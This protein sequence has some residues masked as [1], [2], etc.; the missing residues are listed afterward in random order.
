MCDIDFLFKEDLK[1]YVVPMI[2]QEKFDYILACW[3]MVFEPVR[4]YIYTGIQM[5]YELMTMIS[6]SDVVNQADLKEVVAFLSMNK[7]KYP[8]EELLFLILRAMVLTTW[9]LDIRLLTHLEQCALANFRWDQ[10]L[11]FLSKNDLEGKQLSLDGLPYWLR[12]TS[13]GYA[14]CLP[15]EFREQYIQMEIVMVKANDIQAKCKR[16]GGKYIVALDYGIYVYLQE[17]HR[18]LLH[19]YRL[20]RYSAE[21]ECEITDPVKTGAGLMLSVAETLRGSGSVYQMPPPAMNFKLNDMQIS[22]EMVEVQIR[23]MLG[24]ELGHVTKHSSQGMASDKLI[25]Y[26][27]DD[28]SMDMLRYD[29]SFC[30]VLNKADTSV[31]LP[32]EENDIQSK[33]RCE[34]QIE[35]V[36]ILFVFY[37]LF[38]Y[39]CRRKGYQAP[40]NTAHP[41]P[42]DRRKNIRKRYAANP[43]RPLIEYADSL[44]GRIKERINYVIDLQERGKIDES[45]L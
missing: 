4:R 8:D 25:E 9:K 14:G 20:R 44:V 21:N 45:V 16:I 37:D 5:D 35:A 19:G 41:E 7:N 11:I 22:R 1:K 38:Y 32:G 18:I 10:A 15:D 33:D 40:E 36:E 23:F 13:L 3:E 28:F 24:H 31:R 39:I 42:E 27:A 34:R 26:E 30:S 2:T 12:N 43:V 29:T 17:W 6:Y